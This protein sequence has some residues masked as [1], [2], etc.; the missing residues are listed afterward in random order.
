MTKTESHEASHQPQIVGPW[1]KSRFS[2]ASDCVQLAET[3]D[4]Q[5]VAM[6]NSNDHGQGTLYIQRAA[7]G[8]LVDRIKSGE[9]DSL[10]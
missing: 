8:L 2:P 1:R 4:P 9:L 6:R 5:L 3:A 10:V 7:F